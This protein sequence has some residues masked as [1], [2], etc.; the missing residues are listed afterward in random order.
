MSPLPRIRSWPQFR[1]WLPW[2]LGLCLLAAPVGQARGGEG[3]SRRERERRLVRWEAWVLAT[4]RIGGI[5]QVPPHQQ[6]E[7]F[8]PYRSDMIHPAIRHSY[9]RK[10]ELRVPQTI[11][12][13][14][15][16]SY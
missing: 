6:N 7:Y 16:P 15:P 8:N 1:A 14:Q 5:A 10:A 9:L 11:L 2:S 3:W 12:E 4:H 13:P